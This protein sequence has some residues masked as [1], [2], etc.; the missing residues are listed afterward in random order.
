VQP[1]RIDRKV[2]GALGVVG[3]ELAQMLVA[4]LRVVCLKR[5][6]GGPFCQGRHGLFLA[7][8]GW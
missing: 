4:N 6:P 5:L 2:L 7:V 8:M 1:K 3:E